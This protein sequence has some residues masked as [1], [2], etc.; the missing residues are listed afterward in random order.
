MGIDLNFSRGF[1]VVVMGLTQTEQR[2]LTRQQRGH[3]ATVGSDGWPQ[4]KPLGFTWNA[5][6]GTV[7]I[8]GFNMA[9]SAKYRNVAA[10]PKV[11]FVVDEVTEENEMQGTHFLE[12]RGRAEQVTGTDPADPHLAPEIIRIHPTRVIG[13]NLDPGGPVFTARDLPENHPDAT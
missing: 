9:G 11:A 3:L 4:V 2:F 12:I 10:N 8:A 6:L 7:D 1:S 13:W 5:E